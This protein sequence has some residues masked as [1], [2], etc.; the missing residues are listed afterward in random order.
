[1]HCL[2]KNIQTKEIGVRSNLINSSFCEKSDAMCRS[3]GKDASR[4]IGKD[5]RNTQINMKKQ[6]GRVTG[7]GRYEEIQEQIRGA[8]DMEI[9]GNR[10]NHVEGM[11]E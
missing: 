10:Q 7:G 11:D 8:L 2:I 3:C 6:K 4:Q 9:R 1:M 5:R